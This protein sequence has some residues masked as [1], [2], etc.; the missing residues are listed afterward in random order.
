MKVG[1]TVPDPW[2][3]E[4]ENDRQKRDEDQPEGIIL[5]PPGEIAP[6]EPKKQPEETP[7]HQVV[8]ID[9]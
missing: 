1:T 3:I 8:I 5:P 7:E 2:V 4:E 9:L 6:K